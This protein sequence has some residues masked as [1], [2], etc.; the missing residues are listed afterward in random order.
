MP[1]RAHLVSLATA[2]PPHILWQRDV[3][4]AA[5]RAFGGRFDEFGR[6]AKVFETTGIMKR[7]GVEVNLLGNI[8]DSV[9]RK[10]KPVEP[11]KS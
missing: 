2:V 1:A 5:Q 3:A 6:L 9:R 7:H 10:P 8:V 4:A 11:T